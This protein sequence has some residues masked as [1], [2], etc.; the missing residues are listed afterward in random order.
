MSDHGGKLAAAR[1]P[2]AL[3][4][5]PTLAIV[6]PDGDDRSGPPARGLVELLATASRRIQGRGRAGWVVSAVT[7][8]LASR[9]MTAGTYTYRDPWGHLLEADVS[10]YLERAGFLGAHSP[11]LLRNLDRVVAAGDWVIDV[12]AN[13]GLVASRLCRLVGPSGE[14]WAV[15]PLPRNVERL[16]ALRDRNGLGQLTVLPV[17]LSAEAGTARLRLPIRGG[18]AFGSF[19]ATWETCGEIDVTTARLDDL[20]AE[21]RPPGRLRLVKID[22]EGFEPQVI[23]GATETLSTLRPLVLCE[24]NDILLHQAGTS[25]AELLG[26]FAA[27]GYAPTTPLDRRPTKLTGR[28]VDLLLAHGAGGP[29]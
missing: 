7:R 9:L 26:R 16:E 2:A 8:R 13:V 19:V 1:S 20:V 3:R 11:T 23:A 6:V 25:S 14:V 28:N 22:A 15:E 5:P 4:V 27:L 24:F 18:G 17:A 29:P 10:D 21:R 12:G